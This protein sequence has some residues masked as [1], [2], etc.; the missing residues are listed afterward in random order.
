MGDH[1]FADGRLFERAVE[2]TRRAV[3]AINDAH[4]TLEM[5]RRLISEC[6]QLMAQ[7]DRQLARK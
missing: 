1:I 5:T 2:D 4:N 7:L 3:A 6:R